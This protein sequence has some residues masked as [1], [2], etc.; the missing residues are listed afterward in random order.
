M[1]IKSHFKKWPKK[2]NSSKRITVWKVVLKLYFLSLEVKHV[3]HSILTLSTKSLR[4]KM[5]KTSFS[6]SQLKRGRGRRRR[7]TAYRFAFKCNIAV[8]E[9]STNSRSTT[10]FYRKQHTEKPRAQSLGLMCRFIRLS[11]PIHPQY[12]NP[13]STRLN[14]SSHPERPFGGKGLPSAAW[15]HGWLSDPCFDE[16]PISRPSTSAPPRAHLGTRGRQNPP[17]CAQPALTVKAAAAAATRAYSWHRPLQTTRPKQS[18]T[19]AGEGP[20]RLP[21]LRG[22]EG[23][24]ADAVET[25]ESAPGR[26]RSQQHWPVLAPAPRL[27]LPHWF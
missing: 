18:L 21:C 10:E 6:F 7:P 23:D 4:I 27:R 17:S 5:G 12:P 15:S 8:S 26:P 22:P 14:M 25:R 1:L 11:S 3:A 2:K 24:K 13:L 16:A 20:G 9:E 19:E